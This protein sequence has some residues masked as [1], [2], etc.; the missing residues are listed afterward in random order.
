MKFNREKTL[1]T[2]RMPAL[3]LS[4]TL[5]AFA[6]MAGVL[7]MRAAAQQ[8]IAVAVGRT[9]PAISLPVSA[10]PISIAA[11]LPLAD[12]CRLEEIT[13]NPTRPTWD[14]SAITTQCGIV[15]SD[16]GWLAQPMGGGIRQQMLVSSV[17][18]GLTPRL[19]LRW[20]LTDHMT[21]SGGGTSAL[22]GLG[23]LWLNG[24]YRF[25]N[26][27][28]WTPAMALD[29][30]VKI[31]TAN[32]AKGF[33]S[34]LVDHQ[35]LFL[36]SRDLG[37]THL[38]FNIVGTVTGTTINRRNGVS[39]AHDGAAQFGLAVTRPLTPKLAWIV[40]GYGGPQPGTA[41]RYGACSTGP[42]YSLRP[43]LIFDAA[44]ARAYTAGS[45]RQ[46]FLAGFT[47]AIRPGFRRGSRNPALAR[48]LSQ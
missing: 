14:I 21:Q 46:Q 6:A 41:D 36:A 11:S 44:Y 37:H 40:E 30:G 2:L 23:D 4:S 12:P 35:F 25:H 48:L 32:P 1:K 43:W 26:Q 45:P 39:H 16:T 38:D 15:E 9:G 18:Y 20:G 47:Y 27:G 8:E 28:R 42:A 29:Y 13:A 34:G 17:R 3:M 22:E 5:A 10:A 31:P 24:R 19:D 7:G 33:G